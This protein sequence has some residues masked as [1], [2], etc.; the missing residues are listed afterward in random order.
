[1][2]R[3][4]LQDLDLSGNFVAE[5]EVAAGA[6]F[7]ALLGRLAGL[8]RV[9]LPIMGE[10]GLRAVASALRGLPELRRVRV[11]SYASVSH[12]TRALI[13]AGFADVEIALDGRE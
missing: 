2:S 7:A 11:D 1:M 9:G 4:Y 6:E 3:P 13:F 5:D 12:A 10:Q 8:R